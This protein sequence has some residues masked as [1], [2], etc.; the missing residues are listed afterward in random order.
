MNYI[1]KIQ[2]E[3]GALKANISAMEE[4]LRDLLGYIASEKFLLD[5]SVNVADI[6]SRIMDAMHAATVAE[7]SYKSEKG[8]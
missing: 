1:R 5:R 4:S 6:N 7:Y 3:N 2:A 8:E